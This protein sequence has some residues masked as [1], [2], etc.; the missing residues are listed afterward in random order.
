ML[1]S[2]LQT[3]VEA[4]PVAV[5]QKLSLIEL[6]SKGGWLMIILLILSILAIY[7]FGNKYWLIHKAGK[8]DKNFMNDIHDLIHDGKINSALELCRQYDSPIARLIEKGIE[9]I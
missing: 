4:V 2:V 5:Q 9:R 6:A 3:S 1:F 8:M 7:I